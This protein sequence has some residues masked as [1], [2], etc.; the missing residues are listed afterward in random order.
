MSLLQWSYNPTLDVWTWLSGSNSNTIAG[1]Q[2]AASYISM[3]TPAAGALPSPRYAAV[4][5][6]DAMGRLWYVSA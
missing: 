6:V 5:V 2:A 1:Q 3:G 4:G